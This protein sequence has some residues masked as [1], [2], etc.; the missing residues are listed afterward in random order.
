[1]PDEVAFS[2]LESVLRDLGPVV[3]AFS[4]GA[5]SALLAWCAH[6]TLGPEH[7]LAVTAVS[8]SLAA[9]RAGRCRGAGTGVGSALAGGRDRRARRPGL[10]PQRRRPLLPLQ[11]GA[12]GCTVHHV[13]ASGGSHGRARRQ[14]RRP[15]RSPA[16]PASCRRARRRLPARRSRPHQ[17]RR[18]RAC[19]ARWAC[20]QPT[21]RR[22]RAWRHA[23]PTA[24]RSRSGGCVRSRRR[25]R[26]CVRSGSP[27]CGSVTTATSPAS[28]CPTQ[29]SSVSSPPATAVVAAV[30]DAGYR[31]VTLDLAGL[32]SGNLNQ[33]L[34][35]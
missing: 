9:A 34:E 21:S 33:V 25:R 23:C 31:W 10:R 13:A 27:S 11:V 17:G 35:G 24:R 2:R 16:G 28:R 4:G 30:V 18:A 7:A 32:R 12:D 3:V 14:P 20:A 5:D 19:R 22:R 8:P 29:Q 1:M 6:T 15:R 26:L